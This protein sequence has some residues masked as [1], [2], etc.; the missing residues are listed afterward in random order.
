MVIMSKP[1]D[2]INP[3]LCPER[4]VIVAKVYL[5]LDYSKQG[6]ILSNYHF[7]TPAERLVNNTKTH[8]LSPTRP[9]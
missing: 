8:T 4:I 2:E 9:G 5:R 7:L 6:Q 3:I 1:L